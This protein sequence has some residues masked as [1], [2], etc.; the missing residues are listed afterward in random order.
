MGI[1][2]LPD[3]P[4]GVLGFGV[5]GTLAKEDYTEVL[6]PDLRAAL[7]AGQRLRLVVAIEED[8]Q[9]LELA[10]VWEDVKTAVGLELRH[11]SSWE[12]TAVATDVEWIVR[13]MSTFAWLA[14]GELRRFPGAELEAA[15]AW[16]AGGV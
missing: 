9:R 5:S 2:R 4:P 11:H 16:A 1:E 10:A 13:A 15:A 6:I 8:F 3:M 12:R 14:P 7:D